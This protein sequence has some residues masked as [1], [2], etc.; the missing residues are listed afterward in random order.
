MR[1]DASGAVEESLLKVVD[2]AA[3][4]APRIGYVSIS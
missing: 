4:V 3:L 1:T 2:F